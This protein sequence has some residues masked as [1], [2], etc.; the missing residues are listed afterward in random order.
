MALTGPQFR[1]S[2]EDAPRGW[3]VKTTSTVYRQAMIAR[4]TVAA[5]GDEGFCDNVG[6]SS[7]MSIL[8]I[9]EQNGGA[10]PAGH[11]LTMSPAVKA[12]EVILPLVFQGPALTTAKR[13]ALVY[14]VDENTGNVT[15]GSGIPV[16]ELIEVIDATHGKNCVK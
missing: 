5:G 14:G 2:T 10:L 15:A 3:V 1:S 6:A 9:A 4:Y 16:G 11:T 8:G 7:N 12:L 13:G